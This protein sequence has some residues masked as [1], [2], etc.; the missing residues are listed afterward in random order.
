MAGAEADYKALFGEEE[1]KVAVSKDAKAPAEFPSTYHWLP[2]HDPTKEISHARGHRRGV[3][4]NGR[5]DEGLASNRIGS[6]LWISTKRC[7]AP[8]ANACGGSGAQGWHCH[9]R[10]IRRDTPTL[11]RDASPVESRTECAGATGPRSR[12]S[13]RSLL[14]PSGFRCRMN[15][16]LVV[17]C[18]QLDMLANSTGI[19]F[20]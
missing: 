8:E 13:P 17:G 18:Q 9:D 7:T 16:V 10:T 2:G 1:E 6:S 3:M 5:A 11:A 20:E 12:P 15:S 19:D 4:A 14:H